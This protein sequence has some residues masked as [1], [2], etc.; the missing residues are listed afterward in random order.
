MDAIRTLF[1]YTVFHIGIYISLSAAIMAA[2]VFWKRSDCHLK[3][4]LCLL[5]LAGM[6]GGGIASNIP[7][8]KAA[9]IEQ[10]LIEQPRIFYDRV[11]LL[12]YKDM[13]FLEH[14][15]FWCA[16]GIMLL[17]VLRTGKAKPAPSLE[18]DV[19]SYE[20]TLLERICANEKELIA[21]R[22]EIDLVRKQLAADNAKFASINQ[23]V[24]PGKSS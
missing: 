1:D 3:T 19:K 8:T 4:V 6:C 24:D 22:A 21:L 7:E 16:V 23:E 2:N 17:R 5:V 18:R 14:A 20:E 10:L 11:P 15:F 13:V 9:G 12:R